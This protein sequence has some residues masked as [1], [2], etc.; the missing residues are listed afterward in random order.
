[1]KKS[2]LAIAVL[3][4]SVAAPAAIAAPT[5]YGNVHVSLDTYDKSDG[6]GAGTNGDLDMVSQTSAFGLKGSEDLGDGLKAIYKLEWQVDVADGGSKELGE[7]GLIKRDQFVGLKG[8][9]GTVAF[10][11]MSTNYKEKGGKVDALYRTEIEGRGFMST[12]SQLHNGRSL[13]RGRMTNLVKYT[14]PK[15]AGVQ[16]VVDTTFSDSKDEALGAGLRWSNKSILLFVDYIDQLPFGT[17]AS[18][19]TTGTASAVKVGG[20]FNT[21]AFFIAGQYEN[22]EDLTDFDYVH[23]NGGFNINKNNTIVLTVGGRTHINDSLED[24]QSVMVAYNHKLSKMTNVYAG[25]GDKSSDTADLEDSVFTFGIR[26]K[27]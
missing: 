24:T 8:G 19:T 13:Q 15:M 26:K 21:K 12:Q 1:M 9:W 22:A 2:I 4:A 16:L 6:S 10:G 18:A 20:K 5:V 14:S 25:Y 3:A 27:F 23:V 17:I 11:T 7:A